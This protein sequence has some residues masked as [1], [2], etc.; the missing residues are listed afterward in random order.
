VHQALEYTIVHRL[1]PDIAVS[2]PSP[3]REMLKLTFN[4]KVDRAELGAVLKEFDPNFE[5]S[6]IPASEFLRYFM[7]LGI[8][9]RD[10]ARAEQRQRQL[11]LNLLAE[12]ESTKKLTQA[13]AKMNLEVDY[14]FSESAE[15]SAKEKLLVAATKYDRYATG[16]VALDGFECDSLDPGAFK[17]LI[18]RVFNISLNSGELGYVVQKYD[19]KNTGRVVC[20]S[21][22]TDFLRLGQ[23]ARYKNH[24]EQL[25]KQRLMNM[26]SEEA[27]RQKIVAVQN[28]E[29]IKISDQFGDRH[30]KSALAKITAAAVH[31]DKVRGVS[32]I[33]FEPSNLTPLE[34]KKALKR[35]FNIKLNAQEMGAAVDY[36]DKDGSKTVSQPSAYLRR[37]IIRMVSLFSE[38]SPI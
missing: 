18:R 7:R 27:H 9:A 31:Y 35:T 38:L 28:S 26:Q 14:N 23:E 11:E 20:K 16:A 12:Q 17:D 13:T 6:Q 15:E 25:E 4:L 24:V 19:T 21:F 8:D 29:S 37:L 3:F 5:G 2:F 33:S 34:F 30:I 1:N 36:F 22:L 10:K 32:L